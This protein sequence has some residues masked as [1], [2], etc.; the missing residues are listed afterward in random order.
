MW[1]TRL[2]R[3]GPT[4]VTAALRGTVRNWNQKADTYWALHLWRETSGLKSAPLAP[5][6]LPLPGRKFFMVIARC[7]PFHPG[8]AGLIA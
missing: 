6:P 2:S 3:I 7:L 8:L 1:P 4:R 5:L